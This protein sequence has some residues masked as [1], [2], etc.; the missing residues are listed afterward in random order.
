M[1][2]WGPIERKDKHPAAAN[3]RRKDDK[4]TTKTKIA[5]GL[6]TM[7][8]VVAL[9]AAAFA[10]TATSTGT[11]APG[12]LSLTTSAAPTFSATLDGTDQTKTYTVPTVVTDSRGSGAGWNLTIT[13][14]QFTTGGAT[15]ST[16]ATNA[17][18]ITGVA[19]SCAPGSTCTN[20]TNSVSYPVGVPAAPT[21][22][23]AVKYFNAATST[24]KG[25][26]NNTPSVDVFIP[27]DANAGT[28]SSTLTL[29]AISGP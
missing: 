1:E 18:S 12:A 22:P 26:F 16:L 7:A 23:T 11:L 15:P 21:P 2:G 3:H 13:S 19:N 29:S 14:T 28:Y 25:K 5:T 6:A 4:M 8:A 24:G 9:P 10:A 20:P 27:A 17:S